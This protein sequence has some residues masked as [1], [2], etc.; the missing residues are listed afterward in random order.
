MVDTIISGDREI[1]GRSIQRNY[2]TQ[3]SV[4]KECYSKLTRMV[5]F[6]AFADNKTNNSE[7]LKF[8]SERVENIVEKGENAGK[9]YFLLFPQYFQNAD[10]LLF[11]I[12]MIN[13]MINGETDGQTAREKEREIC[14][15][16]FCQ[17]GI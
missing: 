7:K 16:F 12:T 1:L 11:P 17:Q 13:T 4:K 3:C 14:L 6:K 2:M 5:Q 9:Q 15:P 8:S 10:R